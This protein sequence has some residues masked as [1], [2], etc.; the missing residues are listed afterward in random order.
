MW[1]HAGASRYAYNQSLRL[2]KGALEAKEAGAE[3]EVPWTSFDLIGAFNRWK[4]SADAGQDE[5]GAVG[6]PWRGE[7]LQ[8]VFEEAAAD[9]GKALEAF[10]SRRKAG[11]KG[12]GFPKFKKRSASRQ[13]FRIRN[14]G[15]TPS[16]RLGGEGRERTIRLPKLGVFSVRES[17]RKLRRMIRKGRATIRFAYLLARP[18][19]DPP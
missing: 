6:L 4:R 18:Y 14:K 12:V 11:G 5:N 19:P 1:R 7:V 3:V 15:K 2:V 9:L 13:S 10:S 8:H 17:T 16:I